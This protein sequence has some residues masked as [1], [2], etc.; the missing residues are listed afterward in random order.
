MQSDTDNA[1][2]APTN[3]PDTAKAQAGEKA[4]TPGETLAWLIAIDQ[5]EITAASQAIEKQVDS[6]VGAYA[7]AMHTVHRRNL[8]QTRALADSS[9]V[10]IT[11]S[12]PLKTYRGETKKALTQLG[13]MEGEQYAAAYL[14]AMVDSH[15]DALALIDEHLETMAE[16]AIREHLQATRDIVAEHREHA[17]Q[18]QGDG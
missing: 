15:T 13:T 11:D 10:D 7:D 17:Q 12:E 14:A 1:R 2:S 6:E 9:G 4:A 3:T 18:L 5:Y 8:S 16:G